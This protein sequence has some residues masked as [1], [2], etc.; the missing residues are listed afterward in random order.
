MTMKTAN[1]EV[2]RR[3]AAAL[4]ERFGE[5]WVAD[6]DQDEGWVVY[7]RVGA[8]GSGQFKL[9]FS[10]SGDGKVT[11]ADGTPEPVEQQTEYVA[12]SVKFVKGS[13]TVIEGLGIPF[14]GPFK[15]RDL[16]AEA[17]GPETDFCLDWF[18]QRPLIYDHGTN[19]ATKTTVAGRVVEHEPRDIG[20]WT[21]AELN[22][23][24][25]YHSA[26]GKLVD[27]GAL[28][29]SSGAMP[30]LVQKDHKS[31]LITRWP[32]IELSLTPTPANPDAA[33]YA[34]KSADALAHLAEID[35]AV[36]EPL[37]S[38][39]K[40]LDEGL[41]TK[42]GLEHGPFSEHGQRVS[43]DLSAF[44]D[45]AVE[46]FA[47]RGKVGRV[48]STSNRELLAQFVDQMDALTPLRQRILDLLKD[49]DPDTSKAALL[50][51]A[52][53]EAIEARLHG[54]AI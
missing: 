36:P 48:L 37:A 50:A 47:A 27:R 18:D 12:K 9:G 6:F 8:G 25:A 11:L 16:E 49:T 22:K 33:V 15:G 23:N 19:K 14:G 53:F 4:R 26:I 24:H 54:V 35:S 2:N 10:L 13:S 42:D 44:V 52:E 41:A 32:W 31:G 5:L 34:V 17:F 39:L 7:E 20:I 1:S 40:A 51:A 43:A 38:A 46:R 30:H 45:R 29:F 21:T 3:L 28:A